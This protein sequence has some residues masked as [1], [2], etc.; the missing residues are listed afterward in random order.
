M[1]SRQSIQVRFHPL[2][3]QIIQLFQAPSALPSQLL[4][5]ANK[6]FALGTTLS[7]NLFQA[8]TPSSWICLIRAAHPTSILLFASS[9]SLSCW[10]N[11]RISGSSLRKSHMISLLMV[12]ASQGY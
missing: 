11:A 8:P 2:S 7:F 4:Q 12:F 10:R 1:S 3:Y 9:A 6:L 5:L